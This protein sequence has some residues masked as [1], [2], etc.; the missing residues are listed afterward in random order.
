MVVDTVYS[1]PPTDLHSTALL[2]T[3]VKKEGLESL[4]VVNPDR[5]ARRRTRDILHR[6]LNAETKVLSFNT[7]EELV[8]AQKSGIA[9]PR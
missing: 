7:L 9:I 4:I 1:L 8:S 3:S 2:R 6:G 5:E